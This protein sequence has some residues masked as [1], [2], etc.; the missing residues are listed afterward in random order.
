MNFRRF[1]RS[2]LAAGALL[3]VPALASPQQAVRQPAG[4]P[5]RASVVPPPTERVPVDPRITIGRLDNGLRY[6]VRRNPRPAN[7]AELRLVINAGS[8]LEEDDQ[9]GLAHMVEHMA[10]NGTKHFAGQEI[11]AFMESIGMQF[12]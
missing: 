3:A 2:L 6:Y 7:R 1:A 5:A 11:T 8:V 9:R 4:A 10:F 12:G